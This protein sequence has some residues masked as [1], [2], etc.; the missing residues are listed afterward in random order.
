[1]VY[2]LSRDALEMFT[3]MYG[4]SLAGSKSFHVSADDGAARRLVEDG[5]IKPH[6]TYKTN[7]GRF[8]RCGLTDM[9]RELG[10][11]AEEAGVIKLIDQRY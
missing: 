4:A 5:L 11:A 2:P 9:G 6:V 7:F 10:A 1:M 3:R 8:W